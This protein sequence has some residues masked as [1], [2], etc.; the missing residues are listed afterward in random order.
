VPSVPSNSDGTVHRTVFWPDRLT[1]VSA[2]KV[3]VTE[4]TPP[5]CARPESRTAPPGDETSGSAARSCDNFG[6]VQVFPSPPDK[7]S[8]SPKQAARGLQADPAAGGTWTMGKVRWR[9]D[10]SLG[11]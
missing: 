11:S 8:R 1:D 5:E 2:E 3:A 10:A 4:P 9:V 7:A 6:G